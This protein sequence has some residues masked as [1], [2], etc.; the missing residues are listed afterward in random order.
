MDGRTILIAQDGACARAKD[1]C[2]LRPMTNRNRCP[3][4]GEYHEGGVGAEAIPSADSRG[5]R[6]WD[7]IVL[8]VA[9]ELAHVVLNRAPICHGQESD[10]CEREV[11]RKVCAWGFEREA[12]KMKEFCDAVDAS[13]GL[14]AAHL[15]PLMSL[16]RKAGI[17]TV[18][19]SEEERPGAACI[20]FAG[21]GD[22]EMFLNIARREYKVEVEQW[23][24]GGDGRCSFRVRFLVFFPIIDIP[25][26][27]QAFEEHNRSSGIGEGP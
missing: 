26:L 15:P 12:Q 25:C 18:Q 13:E 6:G 20:E 21:S 19:C 3:L 2:R 22:V 16:L 9:H 5:L 27:V 1:S 10:K 14:P 24:E 17:E 4:R 11:F 8:V 7:T 23:D